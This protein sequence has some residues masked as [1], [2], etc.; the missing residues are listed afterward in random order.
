MPSWWPG[1]ERIVFA[2]TVPAGVFLGAALWTIDA[3]GGEPRTLS[4]NPRLSSEFVVSP[5]GRGVLF[6]ARDTNALWWLPVSED[7]TTPGEPRPT[8]LPVTGT[9]VASLAISADGR[10]IAWTA[11]AS[12][13]RTLVGG[14]RWPRR[15]RPRRSSR[16]PKWARAPDIPPSRRTAGSPSWATAATPATRSSSSFRATARA[17]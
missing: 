9:S 15:R 17:S 13:Q 6:A 16:P 2:V 1:S 10:R 4:A 14:G 5:D 7:A 12:D 3:G 11:A 8:A